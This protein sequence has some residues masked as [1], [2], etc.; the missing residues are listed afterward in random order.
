MRLTPLLL[1]ACAAHDPA[2]D[3]KLDTLS[4]QLTANQRSLDEIK[5][6]PAPPPP[7]TAGLEKRIDALEEKMDRLIAAEANRPTQATPPRRPE[8]DKNK[9][10]AIKVDGYPSDG[11]ADAKVT[12]VW[13]HDYADPYSEKSRSVVDDLRKKYGADLRIVWRDMVVHPQ[14]ATAAAL[15][16]C[17]ANKQKQFVAYD[18]LLWDKGFK[19]RSFDKG[20][21]WD[22]AAGCA[23]ALGFATDLK[24]DTK[25]FQADMK[26]CKPALEAD[27]K[28]LQSFG[29]GA[30]PTWW[31]NGRVLVGAMPQ[32]NFETLI[33]EELA[34]ANQSKIPKGQYYKR[35]VVDKGLTKLEGN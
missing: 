20:T 5:S 15:A 14:V 22:D 6:R 25:K 11:P 35:V 3:T 17:A 28:D 2:L 34:K 7:S 12:M 23:V 21:C 31:I 8:P 24:L 29:V 9:V 33:D 16:A 18:Q 26:A 27:M 4:A 1:A 13:I 10:Y 30:T 19:A 32:E